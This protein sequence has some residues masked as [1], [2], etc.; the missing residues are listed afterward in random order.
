MA[1]EKKEK[2]EEVVD[3]TSVDETTTDV[4]ESSESPIEEKAAP[5]TNISPEVIKN[6]RG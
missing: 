4:M 6:R 3:N 5:K 2:V 1:K